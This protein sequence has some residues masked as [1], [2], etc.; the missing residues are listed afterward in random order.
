MTEDP[1]NLRETRG[2]RYQWRPGGVCVG[3]E[4]I[5]L[6]TRY[7][8]GGMEWGAVGGGWVESRAGAG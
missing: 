4:D 6:E 7:R 3:G 5:V 1:P 2:P 8:G